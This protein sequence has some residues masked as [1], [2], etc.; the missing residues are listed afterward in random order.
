MNLSAMGIDGIR[1]RIYF[2]ES[3]H[4]GMGSLWNAILDE[5]RRNGAMGATVGRGQSGFGA[6]SR[7]H[8]ATLV[9]LSADLPLVREWVDVPKSVERLLPRIEQLLQGGMI[10]IEPIRILRYQPHT[11]HK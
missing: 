10:T 3:D 5:L 11:D 1:V 2:G 4:H 7:I 9:D 6:H 8:T